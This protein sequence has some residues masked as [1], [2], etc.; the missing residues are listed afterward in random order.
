MGDLVGVHAG[1]WF[2][3]FSRDLL[4]IAVHF[5]ADPKHGYYDRKGREDQGIDRKEI[6]FI[7]E[8]FSL[9]PFLPLA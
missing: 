4:C 9:T 8:R 1:C 6:L 3:R 7:F 5:A 2:G